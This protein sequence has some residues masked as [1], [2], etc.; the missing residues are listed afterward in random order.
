MDFS[1]QWNCISNRSTTALN[2]CFCVS[3]FL[4]PLGVPMD[5]EKS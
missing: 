4:I 3:F 5:Y 1:E 2:D